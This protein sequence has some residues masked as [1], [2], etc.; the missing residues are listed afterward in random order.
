METVRTVSCLVSGGRRVFAIKLRRGWGTEKGPVLSSVTNF[1]EEGVRS[2]TRSTV[3]DVSTR[4]K[5]TSDT[6]V[7][8][9]TGW[10]FGVPSCGPQGTEKVSQWTREYVVETICV[11][12]PLG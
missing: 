2:V 1:L 4:I 12:R 11:R 8:L 6:N 10:G 3:V 7:H 9:S 5:R